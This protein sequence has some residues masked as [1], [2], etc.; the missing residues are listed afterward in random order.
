MRESR[1]ILDSPFFSLVPEMVRLPDGTR[2]TYYR[3]GDEREGRPP[4][5][6]ALAIC[7]NAQGEIAL[8]SQWSHPLRRVH[9]EFPAGGVLEDESLEAAVLRELCESAD[10]TG[11]DRRDHHHQAAPIRTRPL[12]VPP[13]PQPDALFQEHEGPDRCVE[14]DPRAGL[15]VRERLHR[16]SLHPFPGPDRSTG[17]ERAEFCLQAQVGRNG[18][19]PADAPTQ[20]GGRM[21][22]LA[23][24]PGLAIRGRTF[25]VETE[26]DTRRG[27]QDGTERRTVG[28]TAEQ[29]ESLEAHQ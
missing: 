2:T 26:H 14:R 17:A 22:H 1:T 10:D 29:R 4:L 24:R 13:G 11:E 27:A 18:R 19:T 9:G 21:R 7:R 6:A 8:S 20:S 15:G 28:L 16:P 5:V 25:D 12:P 23:F 3:S